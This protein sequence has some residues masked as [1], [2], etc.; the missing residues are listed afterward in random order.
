MDLSN[1]NKQQKGEEPDW[2]NFLK[3]FR[4]TAKAPGHIKATIGVDLD[5]IKKNLSELEDKATKAGKVNVTL[6]ESGS[7]VLYTVYDTFA[8]DNEKKNEVKAKNHSPDREDETPIL[9]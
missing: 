8:R 6:C 3:V 4:P 1:N 2:A 7:G 9:D 5:Y